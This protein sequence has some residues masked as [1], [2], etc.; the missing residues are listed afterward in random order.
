MSSARTVF[1]RLPLSF[2]AL[3]GRLHHPLIM[4]DVPP[5]FFRLLPAPLPSTPT[6]SSFTD[7]G[8]LLP[9]AVIFTPASPPPTPDRL[10][11]SVSSPSL[12]SLLSV[13]SCKQ[14]KRSSSSTSLADEQKAAAHQYFL[15]SPSPKSPRQRDQS[16]KR[17]KKHAKLR[18]SL[19]AMGMGM[20]LL[21]LHVGGVTVGV[22]RG[23]GERAVER[24]GK[25]VGV[26]LLL[27]AGMVILRV[28]GDVWVARAMRGGARA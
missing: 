10:P 18:Q 19:D 15:S 24:L 13:F 22:A 2:P 9:P 25:A 11:Q 3:S 23:R 17:K 6:F 20:E 1:C 8:A 16:P 27:M 5:S 4:P 7:G 28:A 26:M 21:P 12:S 14:P